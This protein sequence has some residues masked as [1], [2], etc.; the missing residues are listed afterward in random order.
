[1]KKTVLTL[2]VMAL[3]FLAATTQA[4]VSVT[5]IDADTLRVTEFRGKPPHKRQIIAGDRHPGLYARYSELVTYDEQPLFAVSQ[6]GAPGKSLPRQRAR[7]S[8]EVGEVTEFARF[9]ESTEATTSNHRHWH[10]A[11]GKSTSRLNRR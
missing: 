1:M 8:G 7:I 2:G 6:R 4:Q 10:G 11:P 5:R 9:E 3:P